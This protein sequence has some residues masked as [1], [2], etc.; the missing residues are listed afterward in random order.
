M[1]LQAYALV[2]GFCF[3][4][5][6]FFLDRSG[7]TGNVASAIFIGVTFLFL[8]PFAWLGYSSPLAKANWTMLVVAA[9]FS[10]IGLLCFNR[11]IIQAPE[12]EK[13]SMFLTMIMAQLS[14]PG[15]YQIMS[16]R[17]IPVSKIAGIIT[18]IITVLLLSRKSG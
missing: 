11:A 2:A 3:G 6:P 14:M 18:A 16:I 4:L 7:L 13:G 8:L 12:Q 9:A 1:N 10:A 17:P 5:W 15:I